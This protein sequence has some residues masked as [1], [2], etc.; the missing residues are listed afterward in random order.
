MPSPSVIQLI[1]DAPDAVSEVT[2][3]GGARPALG[4]GEETHDAEVVGADPQ[5]VDRVIGPAPREELRFSP[6]AP[7]A[8]LAEQRVGA[9][10]RVLPR[11]VGQERGDLVVGDGGEGR[12]DR[13]QLALD[14]FVRAGCSADCEV[15]VSVCLTDGGMSKG[16]EMNAP[17]T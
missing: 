10:L 5:C 6:L 2:R 11:Q 15:R 9:R 17:R 8:R 4:V 3:D 12:V 7:A 13:R 16:V 1:E 14:E